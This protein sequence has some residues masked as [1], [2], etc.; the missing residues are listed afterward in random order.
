M[1]L[2]DQDRPT[3]EPKLIIEEGEQPLPRTPGE[4]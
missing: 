1:V 4:R 3:L 2:F